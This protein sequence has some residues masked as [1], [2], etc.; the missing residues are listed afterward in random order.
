VAVPDRLD[1]TLRLVR[2]A[3]EISLNELAERLGVSPMTVRRDL[4]ELQGQGLVERVRGG[5]VSLSA[6]REEAGFVKR[7]PWQAATK[8]KI[9]AKAA[10]L[11]EP[12]QTVLLD[13]GTTTAAV[14]KN[15]VPRAPLTVAVLSLQAA[16]DLA[17]RKGIKLIVLGGESRPGERSLVGPLTLKMLDELWFD[18]FIMSIGAVHRQLGWSEFDMGD[19]AVKQHAL[20][21]ADRTIVVADSTK[22]GVRAFSKVAGLGQVD[23]LVTDKP[24]DKATLAAIRKAG[25]EVVLA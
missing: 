8:K 3:G 23:T 18:T 21:Q 5:A 20:T 1:L 2:E 24:E 19:A 7:E 15:L 6:P 16:G 13:A 12:G 17:D 11:I 9:A 10:A 14:A 22:F 4:D 25:V